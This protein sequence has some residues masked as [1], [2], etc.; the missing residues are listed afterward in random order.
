MR[1]NASLLAFLGSTALLVTT[2]G[3][4]GRDPTY[5]FFAMDWDADTDTGTDTDVGSDGDADTDSETDECPDDFVDDLGRCIRYVD[6]DAAATACGTGWDGAFTNLQDGIDSAYAAAQL[7]GSCEVWVA[8]GTYRSYAAE[9]TDT[10]YLR[11]DVQV[12]GGFAGDET[13]RDERDVEVNETILDGRDELA[14]NASYHVVMG[15]ERGELDGFTITGGNAVGDTPHHRGGGLYS[16]STATVVRNCTFRDNHAIDGG[17][18]FLYDSTPRLEHCLLEENTAE[19]GGAVFVLNGT[20]ELVD[21]TIAHNGSGAR[22]GGVYLKSVYGNCSPTFVNVAIQENTAQLDGGGVFVDNCYP[23]L[24]DSKIVDNTAVRNGGGVSGEHGTARLTGTT[25]RGNAAWASGGGLYSFATALE[26]TGSRVVENRAALHG[27]GLHMAW[28]DSVVVATLIAANTAGGDGGGVYVE[29]DFPTFASSLVTGNSAVRGGGAFNG[30]RAVAAYV[31]TV[32]H[33]N[34]AAEI[35]GGVFNADLS[36][37]DLFNDILWDNARGEIW[38]EKG[39][40]TE[41]AFSDV[42]GGYPGFAVIDADP[43]FVAPGAWSDPGTPDDPSDDAWS[44]GDYH[45]QPG[46]PCIDQADDADAPE[47]DADGHDWQDTLDAG[48]PDVAADIGAYDYQS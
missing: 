42:R 18:V 26:L 1:T 7:L 43:L 25:V 8:A 41:V 22:G 40:E 32:F 47:A 13:L 20:A 24:T 38:D 46:S 14:V 23:E 9:L 37:V 29:N 17:A 31:N 6:W 36:E 27:G 35:G 2:L 48:I 3:C 28:S 21:V 45:L 12:Y 44:D 19:Q 15:A 33:G 34:R 5:P 16:N 30:A 4:D 39:S 10:F 11:T